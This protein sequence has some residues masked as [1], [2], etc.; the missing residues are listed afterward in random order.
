MA[1][2]PALKL[3]PNFQ[4]GDGDDGGD[5]CGGGGGCLEDG[6]AGAVH[7]QRL[8]SMHSINPAV[9]AAA[10]LYEGAHAQPHRRR[11]GG[12]R[13]GDCGADTGAGTKKPG[14]RQKK[15]SAAKR[16]RAST[17]AS[18]T[19]TGQPRAGAQTAPSSSSPLLT[20][21]GGTDAATKATPSTMG[22][23][24]AVAAAAAAAPELT[25]FATGKGLEAADV[26]GSARETTALQPESDQATQPT[27]GSAR[28]QEEEGDG[29]IVIERDAAAE[30]RAAVSTPAAEAVAFGGT[31]TWGGT[32]SFARTPAADAALAATEIRAGGS[33][34]TSPVGA[35][36]YAG[37]LG[38]TATAP[39]PA[40]A[41][42][43]A[44]ALSYRGGRRGRDSPSTLMLSSFSL[45]PGLASPR[46]SG[47]GPAGRTAL[48]LTPTPSGRG[49]VANAAASAAASWFA[50]QQRPPRQHPPQHKHQTAAVAR[51][52]HEGDTENEGTAADP[53]PGHLQPREEGLSGGAEAG[54]AGA[55]EVGAPARKRRRGESN[56]G[57]DGGVGSAASTSA[58]ASKEE[59]GGDGGRGGGGGGGRPRPA[60]KALVEE[61]ML[62]SPVVGSGAA[63]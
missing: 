58:D 39:A 61:M 23:V 52:N 50:K 32:E 27:A 36:T 45:S 35:E 28:G 4:D 10:L 44:A 20:T 33:L 38:Q 9:T 60:G 29:R 47:E 51:L 22:A 37:A 3:P 57:V 19:T 1:Q 6:G 40:P 55:G 15:K 54:V 16:R 26:G 8:V 56:V 2:Q 42:A 21:A 17:L 25:P 49:V 59:G 41:P 18:K 24:G 12:G 34:S 13:G 62:G 31:I 63:R 46:R 7:R 5:G 30:G 11:G 48:A 14:T 53:V 43:P